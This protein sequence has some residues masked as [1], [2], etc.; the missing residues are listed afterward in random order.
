MNMT[1]LRIQ[2]CFSRMLAALVVVMVGPANYQLHAEEFFIFNSDFEMGS[3]APPN[4]APGGSTHVGSIP[5][6]NVVN[7]AGIFEPNF[8]SEVSYPTSVQATTGDF[9]AYSTSN[10]FGLISVFLGNETV[11][12]ADAIY[13]L[14]IDVG[15]RLDEPFGGVFGIARLANPFPQGISFSAATDPGAGSFSRQTH[16]LDGEDIGAGDLGDPFRLFFHANPGFVAD[17]DNVTFEIIVP[18]DVNLDGVVN[19]LDVAGFIDLISNGQF[20]E[21]GDINRDGFVNLLDVGPFVSILA[22]D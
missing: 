15:H 5:G 18:G 7:A 3:A 10:G 11:L 4:V 6:F 9:V 19:L 22:G 1:Q 16:V 17:F 14:S 21:E 8:V 12:R 13:V 2:L 20:Q